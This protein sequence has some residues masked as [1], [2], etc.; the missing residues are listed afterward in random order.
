MAEVEEVLEGVY[1]QQEEIRVSKDTYE[2][3]LQSEQIVV[4]SNILDLEDY[5]VKMEPKAI[6]SDDDNQSLYDEDERLYKIKIQILTSGAF[7]F[8]RQATL[9]VFLIRFARD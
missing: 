2:L 3:L 9:D 5:D 4:K 7:H 6:R 1:V 8:V